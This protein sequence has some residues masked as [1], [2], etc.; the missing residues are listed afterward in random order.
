[1]TATKVRLVELRKEK[2]FNQQYVAEVLG[3]TR[4]G[5]ASIEQ[6][7]SELSIKHL[8]ILTVLYGV[9]ADVVLGLKEF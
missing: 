5:Y 9:S 7:V 3:L 1:M 4:N 2:G 6:G 8:K